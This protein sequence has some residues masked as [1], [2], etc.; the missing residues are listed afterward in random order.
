[1]AFS[2]IFLSIHMVFYQPGE[3]KE[4]NKQL[5]KPSWVDKLSKNLLKFLAEKSLNETSGKKDE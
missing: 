3:E 4:V 1:M 2:F 5:F